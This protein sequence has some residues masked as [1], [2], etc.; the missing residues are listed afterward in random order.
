MRQVSRGETAAR[1][2][3]N[4]YQF[5][6]DNPAIP[7]PHLPSHSCAVLNNRPLKD[8][9]IPVPGNARR[10]NALRITELSRIIRYK[11]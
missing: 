8:V 4:Y 9:S 6:Q 1:S 10:S 7:I 2:L 3:D 5:E 11:T